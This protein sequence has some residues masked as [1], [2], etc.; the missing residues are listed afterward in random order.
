[1]DGNLNI[2]NASMMSAM[3]SPTSTFSDVF[4]IACRG[5]DAAIRAGGSANNTTHFNEERLNNVSFNMERNVNMDDIDDKSNR[6]TRNLNNMLNVID[7]A[8]TNTANCNTPSAAGKPRYNPG[9]TTAG[10]AAHPP[11]NASLT[12][13]APPRHLADVTR[14]RRT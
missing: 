6:A 12:T 14:Q 9:A 8:T 3:I 2:E 10:A 4:T 11:N 13:A 1:M 5:V 7:T